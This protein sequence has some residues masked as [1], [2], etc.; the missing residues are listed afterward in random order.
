MKCRAIFGYL[1]GAKNSCSTAQAGNHSRLC[2]GLCACS[3]PVTASWLKINNWCHCCW[4]WIPVLDETIFP[5]FSCF[6][7]SISAWWSKVIV[8]LC[9]WRVGLGSWRLVTLTQ[10]SFLCLVF[11]TDER[12]WWSASIP[13]WYCVGSGSSLCTKI[14]KW[15]CVNQLCRCYLCALEL[16][17]FFLTWRFDIAYI[18][19]LAA[20]KLRLGHWPN[21]GADKGVAG[22][23]AAAK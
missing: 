22:R 19:N 4:S 3:V 2:A 10:P 20:W 23:V 9:P 8:D 5:C 14:V 18:F 21:F 12:N 16:L 6:S 15:Y 17:S 7:K 1:W 11:C 13:I